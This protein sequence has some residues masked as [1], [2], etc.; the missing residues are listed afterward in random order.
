MRTIHNGSVIV[1]PRGN[2]LV[3]VFTGLGW[4]RHSLFNI[5][6]GKIKLVRGYGLTE[7]EFSTVLE[8]L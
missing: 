6:N 4:V 3:D 1:L 2:G 5:T 8:T 7:N